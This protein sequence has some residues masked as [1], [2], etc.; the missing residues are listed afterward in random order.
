MI[1]DKYL[2]YDNKIKISILAGAIWIYFR[3]TQCYISLP[4]KNII[5][6]LLVS[7]WIYYN[8]QE[9]L[10][11]MNDKDWRNPWGAGAQLSHYLFLV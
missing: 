6:V 1:L 10:F 9:P 11:F 5:S 2:S 3:T 4:R 8:Y 7:F